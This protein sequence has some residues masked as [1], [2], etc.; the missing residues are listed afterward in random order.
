MGGKFKR[1]ERV[2]VISGDGKAVSVGDELI[3]TET[4]EETLY[5]EGTVT[6]VAKDG[7]KRTVPTKTV[8]KKE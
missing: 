6:G 5:R 7:K 8:I 4:R 2:V 3:V 1:G